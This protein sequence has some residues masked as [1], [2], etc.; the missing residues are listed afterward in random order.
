ML[1]HDMLARMMQTEGRHRTRVPEDDIIKVIMKKLHLIKDSL[2][3]R[4]QSRASELRQKYAE[5][6]T[7]GDSGIMPPADQNCNERL[8]T[9][10]ESPKTAS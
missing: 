10:L 2:A 9:D 1:R 7:I 5:A 8:E 3:K 4:K 6:N